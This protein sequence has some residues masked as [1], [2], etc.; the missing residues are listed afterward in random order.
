MNNNPDEED[1][2]QEELLDVD[3]SVYKLPTMRRVAKKIKKIKNIK[4]IKKIKKNKFPREP[5]TLYDIP[6]RYPAKMRVTHLGVD[7]RSDEQ[8]LLFGET[9]MVNVQKKR[10]GGGGGKKT[11][12]KNKG[13]AYVWASQTGLRAALKYDKWTLDGTF[14]CA[15]KLFAQV[16]RIIIIII[17]V[18]I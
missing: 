13:T 7:G 1:Q 8:F 6:E 4:K 11:V 18:I 10:G 15:P 14:K 2:Q 3:D 17:I 12:L 5:D 16:G 9:V